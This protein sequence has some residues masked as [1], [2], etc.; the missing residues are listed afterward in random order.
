MNNLEKARCI[1][2]KFNRNYQPRGCCCINNNI[3]PIPGL[4]LSIGTVTTGEAGTDAAASI[5]G[6]SPNFL[7]NLTIPQG[8]TG[9][10][11][12]TG[13]TGDIGATGPAGEAAT[14]SVGTVT[15][16]EAGTDALVVNSGTTEAAILDFTIPQGVTGPTGPTS[17]V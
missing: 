2:E 12:P 9:P 16:G 3:S 14:I 6:T 1:I 10:T 4:T 11:G 8:V 5:T 13:L 7:L 17:Y 15:T